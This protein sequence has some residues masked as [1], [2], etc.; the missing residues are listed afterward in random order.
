MASFSRRQSCVA[1]GSGIAK[2]HAKRSTAEDLLHLR[3][4][5]EHIGFHVNTTL[6]C[7]SV[8]TPGIA[9]HSAHVERFGHKDVEGEQ[10]WLGHERST[11][12]RIASMA[13]SL[14]NRDTKRSKTRFHSRY[15][16]DELNSFS[17]CIC[18]TLARRALGQVDTRADGPACWNSGGQKAVMNKTC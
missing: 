9:Q 6:W 1:T 11:R 4:I 15:G 18:T 10:G 12:R 3:A 8:A 2:Y 16:D 14:R 5:L 7:D 13:S 17:T